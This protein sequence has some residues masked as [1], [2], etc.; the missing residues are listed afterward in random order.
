[1]TSTGFEVKIQEWDYQDGLHDFETVNYMVIEE[2]EHVLPK[3][4]NVETGTFEETRW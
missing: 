2:G 4:I 1:M 3:G